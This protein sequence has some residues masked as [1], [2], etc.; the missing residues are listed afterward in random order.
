MVVL[1]TERLKWLPGGLTKAPIRSTLFRS[2]SM[3]PIEPM[4]R[5]SRP[6]VTEHGICPSRASTRDEPLDE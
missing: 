4:A 1:R 6:L 3:R 2:H 5:S